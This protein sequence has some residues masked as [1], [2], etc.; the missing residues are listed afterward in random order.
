MEAVNPGAGR[1]ALDY[2]PGPY[3]VMVVDD[4]VV[5]RGLIAR[6]LESDSEVEVV[7]SNSN[8]EQA[9]G[10]LS[11]YKVEVVVL[12][13][14]MPKLDG[15]AALP[16]LCKA[17]PDIKVIM[18]SSP[19]KRNASLCLR[20]LSEGA[21][22]Y[23]LKPSTTRHLVSAR[24]FQRELVD[25]VKALGAAR[26]GGEGRVSARLAAELPLGARTRL[27]AST[28]I[29][30]RRPGVRR[31]EALAIASSTGG[32]QALMAVLAA[33]GPKFA[34]PI[35]VTQHMPPTFTSI[36]AERL[37]K[38]SGRPCREA[39]DREPVL[40]GHTYIAPGDTH[41][42]VQWQANR[43]AI[44]LDDGPPENFCRPAADPMLRSLARAYDGRALA[45]VLTGMGQDGLRGARVLVEAGG[46]IVAQDAATSVVWGMP[47][48][49]AAAGLCAALLPLGEIA[50]YVNR[51]LPASGSAA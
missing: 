36:L 11:R 22:D 29:T 24:D 14:E 20:A 6:A 16:L 10:A 40:P 30:F 37:A 33:L 41:M 2:L 42:L 4:S 49:V 38:A 7:S 25:K 21:A 32:P 28:P 19:T 34:L 15:M 46:T 23:V 31:P 35:F 26:R 13:I 48:A 9:V 5:A 47:G 43:R 44:R 50:P 3:R 45:L 18:V 39:V 8:G 17:D 12:D 27:L 1:A 51:F